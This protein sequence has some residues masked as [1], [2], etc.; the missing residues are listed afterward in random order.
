M[1]A[2]RHGAAPASGRRL[3]V[4]RHGETVDNAAN[5]W[6]GQRDSVLSQR[7]LAQVA[8][9]GAPL[10]AYGAVRLISSDLGRA[11]VTAEAIATACAVTLELDVR[12]REIDAGVWSGRT[13]IEIRREF[14]DETAA[15]AR[16]EDIPR[17]VTGET[18]DQVRV[19]ATAAAMEA[20]QQLEPGQTAILSTHGLAARAL[21]S[22]VCGFDAGQSTHWLG[23]LGNCHW[24]LLQ[25]SPA[26][27]E[28]G[29]ASTWRIVEWNHHAGSR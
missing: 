29:G 15:L 23:G 3:V 25:E 1:G 6:Q 18:V 2:A 26:R 22:G 21:V 27:A 14:P 12:L 16:G 4:V 13:G 7:G 9:V 5:I 24:A 11:R 28:T 20:V 17:G 10:S 8:A 19:R